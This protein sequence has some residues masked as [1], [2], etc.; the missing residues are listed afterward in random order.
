MLLTA[1]ATSNAFRIL[2]QCLAEAVNVDGDLEVDAMFDMLHI[3][4]ALRNSL[5][6]LLKNQRGK[7]SAQDRVIPQA[8]HALDKF[9][10]RG[11]MNP[12]AEDLNRNIKIYQT[13]AAQRS[14][15]VAT[16]LMDVLEKMLD[17]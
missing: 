14:S 15:E 8:L 9:F 6:G 4:A 11:K 2:R 1:A 10:F 17:T 13:L 7:Q 12:T 3:L 16:K 5:T